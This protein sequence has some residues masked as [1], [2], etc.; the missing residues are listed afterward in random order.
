MSFFI[1]YISLYKYL[2]LA[3]A[4]QCMSASNNKEKFKSLSK[5]VSEKFNKQKI[6]K[7]DVEEAV[8]WSRRK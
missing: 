4:I 5:E 2:N 6:K 7:R 3:Y 1:I 8:K